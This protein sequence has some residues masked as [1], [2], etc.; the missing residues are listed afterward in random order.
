[1]LGPARPGKLLAQL[2]RD[3]LAHYKAGHKHAAKC[4]A[5]KQLAEVH[6]WLAGKAALE[7]RRALPADQE[8][9]QWVESCGKEVSHTTIWRWMKLVESFESKLPLLTTISTGGCE[10]RVMKLLAGEIA[11]ATDGKTR[12]QL[13]LDLG[14]R[15]AGG[16]RKAKMFCFSCKQEVPNK[17]DA[18]PHCG[19]DPFATHDAECKTAAVVRV[20]K[21][22]EQFKNV[23]DWPLD[24]KTGGMLVMALITALDDLGVL[25]ETGE[26]TLDGET[27]TKATV[28]AWR[29]SEQRRADLCLS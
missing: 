16:K 3:L 15:T 28:K 17:H 20:F 18:C 26:L 8:F 6:V 1:M 14:L 12:R 24:D 27:V 22:V 29:E 7:A 11:A 19:I 23:G 13:E 25:T 4:V 9:G 10:Q 5:E 2:R 21:F